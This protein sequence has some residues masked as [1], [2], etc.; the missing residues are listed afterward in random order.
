[1]AN[2]SERDQ[3]GMVCK[4]PVQQGLPRP[5]LPVASLAQVSWTWQQKRLVEH[6]LQVA[7]AADRA[8]LASGRPNAA[9]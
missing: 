8:Q 5:D 9:A 2:D 6:G 3:C 7:G 1:M 4:W